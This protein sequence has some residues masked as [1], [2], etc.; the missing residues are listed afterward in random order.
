MDSNKIIDES[1]RA[2]ERERRA[3]NNV[4]A[5]LYA[6]DAWRAEHGEWL[7]QMEYLAAEEEE[8]Q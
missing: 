8:S 4:F 1:L 3:G 5:V 7:K 2:S 6:N